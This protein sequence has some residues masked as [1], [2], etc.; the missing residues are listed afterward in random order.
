MRIGV[1]MV[2]CQSFGLRGKSEMDD[3]LRVWTVRCL[4]LCANSPGRFE[5]G[6]E[7]RKEGDNGA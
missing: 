4:R 3:N 1:P 7:G 6:K 5:I 2:L